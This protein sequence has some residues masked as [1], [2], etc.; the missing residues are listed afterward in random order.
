VT[1]RG[2]F[3]AF[4]AAAAATILHAQDPP[5]APQPFRTGA[6]VVFVDVSVRDGGRMVTG[7]RAEDFELT[8][9]G[10]RQRIEH[11]EATA[12]PID[13]TLVVDVSGSR[14]WT[15]RT[16]PATAAARLQA[17]L[18]QVL[19]LL[20]PEDRVRLFAADTHVQLVLPFSAPAPPPAVERLEFDGLASLYD[21]LAAA[22]LQPSE[23]ARR[24]V[25]VA[26][27]KGGDTISAVGA[28]EIQGIAERADALFHIVMM[29]TE[30][31][32]EVALRGF[33]CNRDLMGIC[34]PTR[35]F[36]TPFQRRLFT[37]GQLHPL[38]ADGQ[39]IAA[40]AAATGGALHKTELL[41]EPSLTGTF[42][43]AFED[44]RSSYVLRYTPE[45]VTR[46]GWHAIDV[47]VRGP[48]SYTVR[49]RR[50]YGADEPQ[51]QPVP[52]PIPSEPR[53]L[54]DLTAA[55]EQRAYPR[56]A[57]GLRAVSDPVRLMK[58]FEAAG[59]PWPAAP[60]REAVLALELAEPAIFSSQP[61]ARERAHALLA[62]FTNLVRDPIEPND[63]E[64]YWHFAVLAM[65]Q[66]S[67]RPGAADPFVARA[68]RRFPD[69]PQFALARA[70]VTDQLWPVA[71]RTV[72]TDERGSPTAAHVRTVRSEYEAAIALPEVAVEARVRF[73]WFL[74]RIGRNGEAVSQ[75][76]QAARQPIADPALR[77]LRLLFLGH[78]LV[79]LDQHERAAEAYR[80]AR[81]EVPA[82]QSA[83]VALMN[84]RL[85][86]GDRAAAEALAAEIET[87]GSREIDPW[88][89]Y[90]QGQYRHL[91]VALTRLREMT[92]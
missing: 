90:W 70:I 64:R 38:T 8:D 40:A 44:F 59:N 46:G 23:P 75:L 33:Q 18:D 2:S 13:L 19:R 62:R 56:F 36:W 54:A 68:L 61:A 76:A 60:A 31:D 78:A 1:P 9:N 80:G 17:E 24:H 3:A 89:T 12:V 15:A 27:T 16:S 20:R 83:R 86:Q 66:G 6:E 58:E 7:L 72:V 84:V 48:R 41:T 63:F 91:H 81:A 5:R 87:S 71:G 43:K 88:W 35:R 69:E 28:A 47:K 92:R 10:V 34:A 42:R 22:L 29:E 26:R 11:V 67:L 55:Y 4:A 51:A 21:S 77:Y 25:V 73:A 85:L 82:A 30:F 39:T 45:G 50:G 57:A 32:N 74:H 79:A 37:G 49:S 53:T 65:L 14:A 52:R